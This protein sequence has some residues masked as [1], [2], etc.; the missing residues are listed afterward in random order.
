MEVNA[1]ARFVRKAPRK[2]RL[3]VD[4]VR[5]LHVEKALHQLKYSKKDAA[6]PV[7][8]LIDSAIANAEHNFDL[9]RD[10]LVIKTITADEGPTYK[11]WKPRAY[12]RATPIRKH[13]THI[14]VVLEDSA[15]TD[16]SED[17]TNDNQPQETQP[18]DQS[19]D[20]NGA[21]SDEE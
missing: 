14:S 2:V 4:L 20:S 9:N 10:D 7:K 12:G 11:R 3:V 21:S 5:G 6:E 15:N 18:T 16:N 8:K 13:T 1:K 17:E 19:N